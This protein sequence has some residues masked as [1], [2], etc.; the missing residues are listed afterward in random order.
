[1]AKIN[2][3]R[4][5]DS[6][7]YLWK[8]CAAQAKKAERLEK[9]GKWREAIAV[10]MQCLLTNEILVDRVHD[11]PNGRIKL[12]DLKW[13][14]ANYSM[15]VK[16]LLG[17]IT[18]HIAEA[19]DADA[20][21]V[22][23][24]ANAS[25]VSG[26][27]SQIQSALA[28][29]YWQDGLNEGKGGNTWMRCNINLLLMGWSNGEKKLG[30]AV[31]RAGRWSRDLTRPV[32]VMEAREAIFL[33]MRDNS[34]DTE[35]LIGL[36]IPDQNGRNAIKHAFARYS[37]KFVILNVSNEVIMTRQ[38]DSG[39][40]RI[41]DD[42]RFIR[43][44]QS[45]AETVN[46]RANV[47]A[48]KMTDMADGAVEKAQGK[49]DRNS[50]GSILLKPVVQLSGAMNF[51]TRNVRKATKCI[52][53]GITNGIY[54]AGM[55]V[56]PKM[57]AGLGYTVDAVGISGTERGQ[58]IIQGCKESAINTVAGISM[59]AESLG[60]AADT[61]GTS[62]LREGVRAAQSQY[63]PNVA[64]LTENT[65]SSAINAGQIFYDVRILNPRRYP[66]MFARRA[67]TA[68]VR[69]MHHSERKSV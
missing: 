49:P 67:T 22:D 21:Q 5:E 60:S 13:R 41:L 24:I 16:A 11:L 30:K 38:V 43:G 64:K 17:G 45:I 68:F 36:E 66:T 53:N 56:G 28:T 39:N 65:I 23:P 33:L 61:L 4:S 52:S 6:L 20:Q 31:L 50:T 54:S 8:D 51:G 1:M 35:S 15:S 27:P 44:C 34:S 14:D 26:Q 40:L 58:L 7:Q 62:A 42:S 46:N 69:S 19:V 10:Y 2:G 48:K 37:E 25:D 12:E 29:V 3:S 57:K 18:R 59:L 32:V 9:K 47:L 63:G 55:Y